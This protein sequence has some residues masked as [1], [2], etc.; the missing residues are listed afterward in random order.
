VHAF[1]SSKWLSLRIDHFIDNDFVIID[2][3]GGFTKRLDFAVREKMNQFIS[4]FVEKRILPNPANGSLLL[5]S[6]FSLGNMHKKYLDKCCLNEKVCLT[7]I[8]AAF[9]LLYPNLRKFT[10]K[11]DYCTTC[12]IQKQN[13]KYAINEVE[14]D[15]AENLLNTH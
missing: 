2:K 5:P 7:T 14:K 6:S 3:R 12:H 8:N 9:Y 13:I 10:E 1:K 15:E 4:N 11:S